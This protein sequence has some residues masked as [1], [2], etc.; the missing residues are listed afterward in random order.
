M[1]SF[2]SCNFPNLQCRQILIL[3]FLTWQWGGG[4]F[5]GGNPHFCKPNL[6]DHCPH[7]CTRSTPT[8][9]G[10]H[11]TFSLASRFN[12]I[13]CVIQHL[14]FIYFYLFFWL[15]NLGSSPDR[16]QKSLST[17][18][19]FSPPSPSLQFQPPGLLMRGPHWP[20]LPS[21]PQ[22]MDSPPPGT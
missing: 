15:G 3:G 2:S 11:G 21:P 12:I 5:D 9:G 13:I 20:Q 22:H 7:S 17:C 4:T 16:L 6:S 18:S 1:T 8:D 10:V 14:P 19:S